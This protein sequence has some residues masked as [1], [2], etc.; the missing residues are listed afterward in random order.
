[1]PAIVIFIPAKE[2]QVTIDPATLYV[3]KK[4]IDVALEKVEQ[5]LKEAHEKKRHMLKDAQGF[6]KLAARRLQDWN[7]NTTR[8]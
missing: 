7:K 5:L 2:V 3:G 4:A 8:F 1:M 6:L